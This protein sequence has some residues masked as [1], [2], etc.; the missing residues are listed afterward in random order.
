MI[1]RRFECSHRRQACALLL[2]FIQAPA[3]L[4]SQ[5]A[6]DPAN[7]DF[8]VRPTKSSFMT[9]EDVV[10]DVGLAVRSADVDGWSYGIKHDPAV[11]TLTE[12]S[13]QGT[14]VP[15]ILASG[16]EQTSTVV[17]ENVT[18]GYFQAVI[19][20]FGPDPVLL[21]LDDFFSMSR[22]KYRVLQGICDQEPGDVASTVEFTNEL[23]A[24]PNRPVD[25]VITV[26]GM[27]VTPARIEGADAVIACGVSPGNSL[28]LTF[29]GAADLVADQTSTVALQVVIG[30][31]AQSGRVDFLGWSYGL[32]L[33]A[34][35]LEAVAGVPGAD[36]Q[37]LKGGA[38]PDFAS[39]DLDDQSA[40]GS[41]R[42]V[43]VGV[44]IDLGP[45]GTNVLS[46]NAGASRHIDTITLRSRQTIP[47]NGTART[48]TIRF[49]SEVLGGDPTHDPIEV[50]FNSGG[51]SLT[52][53]F[54]ATK[55]LNLLPAGVDRPRFLR[56]DPN[57]D[58]RVDIADG[59]WIINELFYSGPET[60]CRAAADA[61]ADGRRDL[62][63]AMFI[64]QFQI[65][66]MRTPGNLFPPPP[67]PF[68]NCGTADNVTFAE[69]PPGSSACP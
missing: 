62:S 43:T 33:D 21:P 63:D 56:G 69:C 10:I 36:S 34:A 45:P 39:Y 14:E 8:L 19:L 11:M 7:Y 2:L 18:V 5:P 13:T 58:R 29:G 66:P 68:P 15:G 26:G 52:P 17:R 41:T 24:N 47:S 64:I 50:I 32:Q 1:R 9:G 44:V 23:G 53:D 20:T 35:E 67:A 16:F 59:V 25:T 3:V 65:Q 22:A 61:N 55:T 49:V 60:L 48:T 46:V 6:P 31:T 57:N 54:A 4:H 40:D 30:N 37:A 38:G 27:S 12:A 42:G 28:A 51:D